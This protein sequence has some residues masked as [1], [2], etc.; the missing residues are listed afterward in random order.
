[1]PDCPNDTDLA[2]FL[3]E[4]L[5]GERLAHVSGHVDGCPQ[6]QARL[7]RLT[8]QTSGAVAR[9]TEISSSILQDSRSGGGIRAD[10]DT[11]I[12]G[13]RA[14]RE[15]AAKLV[16]LPRVPGFEIAAEIGRG[17]MGVVY[18]ARHRR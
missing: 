2:G 13:A 14:A 4:S 11:Q 12:L 7:D 16:G 18:K 1:M 9:Y 15:A 3:N 6:C 5:T 10:A 17:G 8:E